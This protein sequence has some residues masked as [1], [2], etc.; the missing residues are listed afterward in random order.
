M[1][2]NIK[3]INPGECIVFFDFDNTVT[4]KDVIDDMVLRFSKDDKWIS[5][6]ERWRNGEI[7]SRECLIGQ[8]GGIRIKRDSLNKY[9]SKIRIDPYFKRLIALFRSYR[10][11][12]IILTDN[13]DYMLRIILR[14]N[15]INGLKVYSNVLKHTDD[16]L[17]L[18]FPLVSKKCPTCAHCKKD[19]MFSSLNGRTLSVYIG[20]GQSDICPS[21]HAKLVFAK[22]NLLEYYRNNGLHCIPYVTLRDVY[23]YFKSRLI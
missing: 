11:K 22:D 3:K 15:G 2:N 6:E 19:S 12:V 23:R 4:V 16:R 5:L 9:L 7:G 18:D 13:F 21:K 17:I 10:M 20:D 14:K 8:M 1:K